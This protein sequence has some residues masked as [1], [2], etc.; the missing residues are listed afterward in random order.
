MV[1]QMEMV[2]IYGE[3]VEHTKENFRMDFDMEK[4]RKHGSTAVAMLDLGLMIN[5]M[6]G[7]LIIWAMVNVYIYKSI[8][9]VVV[10]VV[11]DRIG[12]PKL[13]FFGF[14]K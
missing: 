7:G 14:W 2:H 5:Q 3:M 4:E 1:Y 10:C 12:Y 6:G 11:T 13:V 9:K 8:Y